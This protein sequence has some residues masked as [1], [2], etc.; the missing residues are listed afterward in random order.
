MAPF[1]QSSGC[2]R[3]SNTSSGAHSPDAPKRSCT[4]GKG[5]G[6]VGEITMF[7]NIPEWAWMMIIMQGLAL[8]WIERVGKAGD[9]NYRRIMKQL[10]PDAFRDEDES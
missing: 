8:Y 4:L 1:Y 6:N 2:D 7:D 10:R 3:L 5:I 9:Q